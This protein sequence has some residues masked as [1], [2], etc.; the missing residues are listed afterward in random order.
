MSS[1]ND[2]LASHDGDIQKAAHMIFDKLHQPTLTNQQLL[3]H[4][5]YDR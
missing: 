5:L 2:I 1:L 3:L 4:S